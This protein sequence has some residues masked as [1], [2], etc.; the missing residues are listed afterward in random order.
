MAGNAVKISHS[1]NR[2]T[3]FPISTRIEIATR[4]SDLRLLDYSSMITQP[5]TNEVCVRL[6]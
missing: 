1:D 5:N 3:Q 6:R 2:I 4:L